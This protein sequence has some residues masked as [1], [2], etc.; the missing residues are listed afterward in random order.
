MFNIQYAPS[1]LNRLRDSTSE[2]PHWKINY[3]NYTC[4]DVLLA[5]PIVFFKCHRGEDGG[6]WL[7][8]GYIDAH[9]SY[10][11]TAELGV[12]KYKRQPTIVNNNYQPNPEVI[13]MWCNPLP[14]PPPPPPPQTEDSVLSCK[15]NNY[16]N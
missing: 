9:Y 16:Q 11:V 5:V 13:Q 1:I 6:G 3:S 10:E 15:I 14:S 4:I 12:L 8:R 7:G 2:F